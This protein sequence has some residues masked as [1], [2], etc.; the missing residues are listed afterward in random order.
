MW[1][2]ENADGETARASEYDAAALRITERVRSSLDLGDVLQYSVDELG[3]ATGVSRSLIQL[4]PGDD[5]VSPLVE[6]DRG[7]TAPLAVRPPTVV[8]PSALVAA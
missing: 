7:D 6:W 2:A 1:E 3:K 8:A 4:K 5:G